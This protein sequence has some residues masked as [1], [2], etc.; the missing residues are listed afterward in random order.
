MF[1]P[2][3][4]RPHGAIVL[5]QFWNYVIKHS[6]KSDSRNTCDGYPLTGKVIHYAKNYAACA[7]QHG[8]NIFL[9]VY[10]ALG[11]LIIAVGAINSYAQAPPPYE[12]LY[13]HLDDQYKDWYCAKHGT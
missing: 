7:S 12:P 13:V 4:I 11:C 1:G 5:K 2:P 10:T 9:V 8:F 3:F 6:G